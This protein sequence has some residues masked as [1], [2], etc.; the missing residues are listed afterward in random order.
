MLNIE[1]SYV[2]YDGR[3]KQESMDNLKYKYLYISKKY[4]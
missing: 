4:N 2:E 1:K 3:E